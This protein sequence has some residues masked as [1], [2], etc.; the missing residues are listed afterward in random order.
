MELSRDD[1]LRLKLANNRVMVVG[2]IGRSWHGKANFI[3]ILVD[4]SVLQ[5]RR[6]V[7]TKSG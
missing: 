6:L 3:N 1:Q 4:R 5:V 2:V 7:I